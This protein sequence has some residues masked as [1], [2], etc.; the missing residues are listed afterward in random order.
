MEG[1]LTRQKENWLTIV[2]ILK[3]VNLE[4]PDLHGQT[5]GNSASYNIPLTLAFL[6]RYG[7]RDHPL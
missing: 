5:V 3:G 1:L 2:L 6:Q 7:P 4:K